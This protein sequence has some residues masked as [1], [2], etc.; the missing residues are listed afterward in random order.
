[1]QRA[2]LVLSIA[3]LLSLGVVTPALAASPTNDTYSGRTVIPAAPFTESVDTTEATPDADD[4][5][6]VTQCAAPAT[7][8]SVWYEYTAVS[9]RDLIIEAFESD[10]SVGI[11]VATGGPGSFTVV[12]CAPGGVTLPGNSG[13]T[14]A[15]LLFD[16]QGDGGGT[17][18]LLTWRLREAPLPRA[19]ELTLAP[20]GSFDPATGLA[21][22]RGTV[23]CTDGEE[24]KA[25]IDLLVTQNVGRFRLNGQGF[26]TFTCDGETHPWTAEAFSDDGKFGGGKASVSMFAFV[27][28]E[29]G[30]DEVQ[31]TATVT[32]RR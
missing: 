28:N 17:G 3:V 15:I 12:A 13:E 21:T 5:E 30:C 7:D 27:C 4:G 9:D 25:A 6:L 19:L 22:I 11:I 18:G 29:G 8:A 16:Y 2:T 24:G 14:Y 10:F 20:T 26:T 32:L 31:V 23:N 1:M